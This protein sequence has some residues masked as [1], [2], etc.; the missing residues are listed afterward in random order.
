M[1]SVFGY[2]LLSVLVTKL[3]VITGDSFGGGS[4]FCGN[5]MMVQR[6]DAFWTQ[7]VKVA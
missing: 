7:I 6:G 5:Y 2:G 4:F 3:L 1:T